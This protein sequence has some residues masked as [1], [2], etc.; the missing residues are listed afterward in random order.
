MRRLVV[1]AAF[2]VGTFAYSNANAA[3][4]ACPG[5]VY[6]ALAANGT[7]TVDGKIVDLDAVGSEL[8]AL[9]PPPRLVMYYRES[10][11]D[12]PDAAQDQRI[13][14][15]L[16][17]VVALNLPI[18]FSSMPDFSNVMNLKTGKSRPAAGCTGPV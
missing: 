7:L 1:A 9:N 5:V 2:C 6:I 3:A 14:K 16:D 12:D 8:R 10:A 11:N 17:A 18:G 15:A 13:R 4:L